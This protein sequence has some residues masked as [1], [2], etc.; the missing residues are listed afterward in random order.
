MI[1]V[2]KVVLGALLFVVF[3]TN[4]AFAKSAEPVESTTPERIDATVS[5]KPGKIEYELPYPGMLP[6]NPLYFLKTIRDAIVKALINDPFKRAEFNL[7]TAQKRMYAAKFLSEKGKDKLTYETVAKSNNYYHEAIDSIQAVQKNS[8]KNP[9][10]KPF[11]NQAGKVSIKHKEILA[12][13]KKEIDKK[14]QKDV[15]NEEKRLER[16]KTTI[17]Q[18]LK[19]Y[20]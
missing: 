20:L 11:L 18:M 4:T 9:A 17:D 15:L 3:I 5:A 6:D 7:L 19:L 8:P 13:I 14:Y 2:Y 12:V 10:I 16:M 1:R